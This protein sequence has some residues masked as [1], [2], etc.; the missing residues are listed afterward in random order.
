[1]WNWGRVWFFDCIVVWVGEIGSEIV[2]CWLGGDRVGV[3]L[4]D[5]TVSELWGCSC[6]AEGQ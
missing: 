4:G 1:M 3:E 6:E 2:E 5:L